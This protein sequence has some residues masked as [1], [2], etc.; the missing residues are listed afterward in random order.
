[1][2]WLAHLFL[3]ESDP[4]VCL[5]NLLGDLVKGKQREALNLKMQ[6][7]ISCHQAI[8]IFT[9]RHPLV[10]RSK[11]RLDPRYRRFAG[12][13]VDVFYDYIL[14]N[15]WQDYSDIP[16][17]TFTV[18]IYTSWSDYLTTL[19]IYTQGV[20]RRLVAED[21][22]GS[23]VSLT[24]IENTLARISW[25][26]NR[27]TNRQY[28]LTPAIEQLVLHYSQLQQDFQQFFPQLQ[29]H[30]ERWHLSAIA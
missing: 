12:I 7:G 24:G 5:G 10:K 13:L 23:Y 14:A 17:T 21:W 18:S 9:D 20:I 6:R 4:E 22:L 30:I 2:N 11:Q 26:L 15:N 28:D 29:S 27:R 8:D 1:M 19:P 25:K 16:L 3:A